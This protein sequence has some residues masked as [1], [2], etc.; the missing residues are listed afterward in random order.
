M[1]FSTLNL[2][3][4]IS[5]YM[6]ILDYTIVFGIKSVTYTIPPKLCVCEFVKLLYMA[7]Y[8]SLH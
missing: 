8:Y 4:K 5:N 1:C 6:R 2:L 3:F 7:V